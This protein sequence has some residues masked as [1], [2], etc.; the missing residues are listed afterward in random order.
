DD[1]NLRLRSF[2][3]EVPVRGSAA[4]DGAVVVVAVLCPSG[5]VPLSVPRAAS[6]T[7]MEIR[8]PRDRSVSV[9]VAGVVVVVISVPEATA[10]TPPATIFPSR[11]VVVR[12][13][14]GV[15]DNGVAVGPCCLGIDDS[16][17]PPPVPVAVGSGSTMLARTGTAACDGGGKVEPTALAATA[18]CA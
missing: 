6:P 9:V 15:D 13:A 8:S 18:A 2:L 16:R 3:F 17:P 4:C 11:D 10:A 12:A 5:R 1:S 7:T 14:D